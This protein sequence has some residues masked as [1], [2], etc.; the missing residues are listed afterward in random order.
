MRSPQ[1]II[2]AAMRAPSQMRAVRSRCGLFEASSLI[3]SCVPLSLALSPFVCQFIAQGVGV[4]HSRLPASLCELSM[5][6]AFIRHKG[7][8]SMRSPCSDAHFGPT[9][10]VCV[11]AKKTGISPVARTYRTRQTSRRTVSSAEDR[12]RQKPDLQIGDN[13]PSDMAVLRTRCSACLTPRWYDGFPDH[14]GKHT[15]WPA[16]SGLLAPLQ[17]LGWVHLGIWEAQFEDGPPKWGQHECGACF[18]S[19]CFREFASCQRQSVH[20]KNVFFKLGL[21]HF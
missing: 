9:T 2:P 13:F 8:H 14:F 5:G 12:S 1:N 10:R 17:N 7:P 16:S 19:M 3:V 21:L 20:C 15:G 4:S 11:I 6:Q 18:L